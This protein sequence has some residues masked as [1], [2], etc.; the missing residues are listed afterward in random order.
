MG[1]AVSAAYNE[2]CTL[3]LRGPLHLEALRLAIQQL[4]QRHDALRTTFS[5]PGRSENRRDRQI[6]APLV[7][8]S[9]LDERNHEACVKDLIGREI[10]HEFDLVNGPLLR[11]Q[12]VRL[13]P[14][15]PTCSSSRRITSS[16]TDGR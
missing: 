12:I 15:P 3:R 14:K 11:T 7:D 10:R 6:E 4:V 5:P 8:F 13:A 9:D 16:A 1:A 2:S